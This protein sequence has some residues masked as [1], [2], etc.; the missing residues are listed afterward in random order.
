MKLP[1]PFTLALA[2]TA[3]LPACAHAQTATSSSAE[4]RQR[5]PAEEVVYFV[6]PDRF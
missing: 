2:T 5:A 1:A 4:F 6:L 3:L